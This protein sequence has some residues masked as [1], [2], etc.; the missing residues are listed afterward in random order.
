MVCGIH[1][2]VTFQGANHSTKWE[3]MKLNPVW[4]EKFVFDVDE[5]MDDMS[6]VFEVWDH[7]DLT[8]DDFMGE[9]RFNVQSLKE[10]N[11]SLHDELLLAPKAG[12]AK[13]DYGSIK[14]CT[15]LPRHLLRVHVE[16]P[17]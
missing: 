8:A 4:D 2:Q 14:V 6:I 5:N 13:G 16:F 9:A 3:M 15:P 1:H 12:Q 11:K 7:D 10:A 17:V